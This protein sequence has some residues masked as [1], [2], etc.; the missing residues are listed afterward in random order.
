[1][2]TLRTAAEAVSGLLQQ[3]ARATDEALTGPL[4]SRAALER[5]ALALE[6]S[7]RATAGIEPAVRTL[8]DVLA[9]GLAEQQARAEAL[10]ARAEELTARR[11][12][13]EELLLRFTALGSAAQQV[14]A[15][16]R[17]FSTAGEA[18]PTTSLS[19]LEEAV[20]RLV[21]GV[22]AAGEDAREREFEDLAAETDRL[23]AELSRA[24]EH[25]RAAAAR[26][27]GA[28]LH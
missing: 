10:R 18:L 8:L 1:M 4:L 2:T 19:D 17:T 23:Q 26:F 3:A 21:G 11:R 28:P 7:A 9:A 16:L 27:A 13:F 5:T 15:L 25:L 22:T 14:H 20:A 6:A 12:S 24:R